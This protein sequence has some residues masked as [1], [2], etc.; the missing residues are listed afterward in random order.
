MR[1]PYQIGNNPKPAAFSGAFR[2]VG[3][4]YF[5]DGGR[6]RSFFKPNEGKPGDGVCALY[7]LRIQNSGCIVY[8]MAM[9]P[10]Y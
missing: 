3:Y 6:K 4:A 1:T 9:W 5:V 2:S 10:L 8:D 7:D